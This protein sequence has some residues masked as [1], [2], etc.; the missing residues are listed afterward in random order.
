MG[1]TA[2]HLLQERHV[3]RYHRL[4]PG[5][6]E[7]A[8]RDTNGRAERHR[9]KE[10]RLDPIVFFGLLSRHFSRV[11]DVPIRGALQLFYAIG[12]AMSEEARHGEGHVSR[13]MSVAS[14]KAMATMSDED[15]GRALTN[16]DIV[17]YGRILDAHFLLVIEEIPMCE[18]GS[19]W[20]STSLE[21]PPS[22]DGPLCLVNGFRG[23]RQAISLAIKGAMEKVPVDQRAGGIERVLA[24]SEASRRRTVGP[25]RKPHQIELAKVCAQV[26]QANNPES[27]PS[28]YKA[29]NAK[30]LPPL[31]KFTGGIF[32]LAKMRKSPSRIVD[33]LRLATPPAS[34]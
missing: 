24:A 3:S 28:V 9:D 19:G 34:G 25:K 22:D 29:E 4:T 10:A 32:K 17:T 14:L 11:P 2:N 18:V 5:P 7:G 23:L 21:L 15:L 16:C 30:H 13:K 20:E 8:T 26:W 12:V 1:K 31:I 6:E 27:R 33:L